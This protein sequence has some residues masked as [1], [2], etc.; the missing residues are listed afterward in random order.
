MKRN[1]A[2]FAVEQE[3]VPGTA[4]P[5]VAADVLVRLRNGYTITPDAELF[6]LEEISSVSS[7]TAATVGRRM[8]NFGVS[9]ILRGPGSTTV[10]PAIIDLW[11]SAMFTGSEASTI[12][13]N[14]IVGTFTAGEIVTGTTSTGTV[15]VLQ[16]TGVTP[17]AYIPVNG[18]PLQSGEVL[19]GSTSGATA[20]STGAPAGVGYG[21]RPADWATGAGHHCTCEGLVDGMYWQG[22]GCLSDIQWEFSNGGPC[23]VTQNF[24]GAKSADGDKALYTVAEYPEA[25]VTVPKFLD[26]SLY[27]ATQNPTGI[28]DVT[29]NYPTNPTPVEDANDSSGDGI[30]YCDYNRELPTVTLEIDQT[31]AATYDYFATFEAGT[32][33]RFDFTHG[34][35]AGAMWTFAAPAAQIRSIGTGERD[36]NRATFQMELGLT[37]DNNNELLIWQH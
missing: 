22:R 21:F 31:L 14:T 16:Q 27:I 8:V 4:I 23:I 34:S 35:A 24:V 30:L 33:V 29:I 6:D 1:I 32:T 5:I 26:A 12:A 25:S 7:K 36:P 37:G 13:M 17:L 9:Y 2:Q 18:T 11:E 19:T 3:A 15:M 20:N 10:D 28:V